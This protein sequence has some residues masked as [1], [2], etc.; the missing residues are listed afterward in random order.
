M[1]GLAGQGCI[2]TGNRA[3]SKAGADV[4]AAGGNAADAALAALLALCVADPANVSLFGRCHI[5]VRTPDGAVSAI[6]GATTI[7]ART[8]PRQAGEPVRTGYGFAPLPGLPQ[9][10]E[11]CHAR[12]G[13]LP[14][15]RIAAPAV[16]LA[17]HGLHPAP[18]LAR[19]W[20][21]RAPEL[22]LNPAARAHYGR[23]P[24]LFRHP[25]LARLLEAFGE[26]GAAAVLTPSLA[27]AVARAGGD[28]SAQDWAHA[29]ARDGEVID[30]TFRGWRLHTIGRQGW[31]HTLAQMLALLDALPAGGAAEETAMKVVL[32]ILTA[33]HDRPQHIGNLSPKT[34]GLAFPELISPAFIA[35]RAEQ[36][37]S[38]IAAPE[39]MA[40]WCRARLNP[41]P[42]QPDQDTTHLSVIDGQGLTV[43]LTA[44]MG[45]HFGARVAEPRSGVLLANSYRMAHDPAPLAR[46][47]TEMAPLIA[48]GPQGQT[49]AIG[50]AGSERIPGAIAQVLVNLVDGGMALEDAIAA[51]RLNCKDGRLRLSSDLPPPVAAAL[52]AH[53]IPFEFAD[54]APTSHLGIVQAVLRGADGQLSGAADPAYDGAVL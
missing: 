32:V 40:A 39:E 46:D 36:I 27:D 43:S 16:W 14:L 35:R 5:L 1:S 29:G 53:G 17:T 25:G 49:L 34:N 48:E 50:A 28:W 37:S 9:A 31:G 38:L 33:L 51:P 52:A 30:T 42:P 23:L 45:Q 10:L 18:V 21:S 24:G 7:P 44:S 12:F 15:A 11:A 6:D 19:I 20:R 54:T 8:R 22:A 13:R 26:G 3:A 2:A 4:L 41:G 47:V